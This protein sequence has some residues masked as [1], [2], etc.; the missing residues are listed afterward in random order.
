MLFIMGRYAEAK[1]AS[2]R[3][4]DVNCRSFEDK[5]GTVS[6]GHFRHERSQKITSGYTNHWSHRILLP[7]NFKVY[8]AL[9]LKPSIRSLTV[10]THCMEAHL[11]FMPKTCALITRIGPS[12]IHCCMYRFREPQAGIAFSDLVFDA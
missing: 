1:E 5:R 3:E 8:F 2:A 10:T 7:H 11:L 4:G 6:L 9:T 12:S